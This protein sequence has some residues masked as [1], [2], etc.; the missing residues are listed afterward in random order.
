MFP[1]FNFRDFQGQSERSR[2][3]SRG[4]VWNKADAARSRHR[5]AG[6]DRHERVLGGDASLNAPIRADSDSGEWLD[7]L[8]DEGASQETTLAASDE[9]DNRREV[10][11]SALAVLSCRLAATP[12]S[13]AVG[14]EIAPRPPHR[15][16]RAAFP[17]TA[18]MGLSLSRYH[19]LMDF[20]T[21]H[22]S[23]LAVRQFV[24]FERGDSPFLFG[25]DLVRE[26]AGLKMKD[27]NLLRLVDGVR[28][29]ERDRFCNQAVEFF[30]IHRAQVIGHDL[31]IVG[32]RD[33]EPDRR[34]SF[35]AVLYE[36][37]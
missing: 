15:S 6:R 37:A 17:H 9:F 1:S 27:D 28:A 18:C 20:D 8:V 13:V 4:G 29:V 3:T 7:R 33:H 34:R 21:R 26:C 36:I 2:G 22:R 30:G 32:T 24:R 5:G 23:R 10:L 14:T 35:L 12:T 25:S 11:A 31:R 19:A 16:V